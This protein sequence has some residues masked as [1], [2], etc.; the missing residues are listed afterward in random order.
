MGKFTRR[1]GNDIT[2]DVFSR[3]FFYFTLEAIGLNWQCQC[4]FSNLHLFPYFSPLALCI[5][6]NSSQNYI[7]KFK[8]LQNHMFLRIES[9]NFK[10]L[11]GCSSVN[12][13]FR[14]LLPP[15][16]VSNVVGC[17]TEASSPSLNLVTGA[18]ETL[19]SLWELW[20]SLNQSF[21]RLFP[22]PEQNCNVVFFFFLMWYV[23]KKNKL[24]VQ[25]K[26][27]FGKPYCLPQRLKSMLF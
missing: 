17:W 10:L 26:K 25:K 5:C 13:W 3:S 22:Q 21:S 12:D 8:S 7:T 27:F 19:H 24:S 9:T 2:N 6:K 23:Q 14:P 4:G 20:W 1:V 11:L 15:W 18:S 16:D